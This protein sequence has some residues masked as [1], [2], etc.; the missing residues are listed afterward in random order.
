MWGEELSDVVSFERGLIMDP[1]IVLHDCSSL[2]RDLF[3]WRATMLYQSSYACCNEVLILKPCSGTPKKERPICYWLDKQKMGCSAYL[4]WDSK[5]TAPLTLNNISSRRA[6]GIEVN[7]QA[8][9]VSGSE[10][11]IE[12]KY[13]KIL[14]S[15]CILYLISLA[16]EP[17]LRLCLIK[18]ERYTLWSTLKFK[19]GSSSHNMSVNIIQLLTYNRTQRNCEFWSLLVKKTT[20]A[21]I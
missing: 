17:I 14:T 4:S 13:W 18:L 21:T 2:S 5:H 7:I 6:E 12:F 20:K 10:K 3:I 15:L 19:K 9:L 16:S 8:F 1:R 11:I